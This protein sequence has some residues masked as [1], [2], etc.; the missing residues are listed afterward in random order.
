MIGNIKPTEL[1]GLLDISQ[2]YATQLIRQDRPWTRR[3]A[4]ALYRKR[5]VRVGPLVGATDEEI[6]VLERFEQ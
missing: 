2:P 3:L 6:D 5:G 4:I 1:A